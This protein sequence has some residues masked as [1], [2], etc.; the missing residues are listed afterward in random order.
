MQDGL[1]LHSP[2]LSA[3]GKSKLRETGYGQPI[4][5]KLSA[6]FKSYDGARIGGSPHFRLLHDS[7]H[8]LP[9]MF[10]THR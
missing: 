7:S 1:N 8:R 2:C 10:A 4:R 3:R 5:F 6:L 9:A